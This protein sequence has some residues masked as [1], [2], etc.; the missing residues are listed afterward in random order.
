MLITLNAFITGLIVFEPHFSSNVMKITVNF[1][2]LT[3]DMELCKS[4]HFYLYCCNVILS[5]ALKMAKS[6]QISKEKRA[7]IV[8]LNK[9]GHSQRKIAQI[10]GVSQKGVFSAL[11][12]FAETKSFADRKRSGR[13]RKTTKQNDR[14]I[15]MISK[16]SRS[17]TV[18]DIRAEINQ[19]LA[20]PISETTVTRRLHE[21]G[22]YGR[23]AARKPL[24]RPE[25]I[26]KRLKWAKEHRNWTVDQWKQVMWT[27]ESKFEIFGSKR[28]TYCRRRPGERHKPECIQPT[29][30]FGGGSVMVWGCFSYDG[31]GALVKIDGIMRKEQYHQILQRSAIP[32][33]INLIG[34]GF[35]FQQDNDPK[36]TS[37]LCMNYLRSKESR[38]VLKYMEWPPQSPDANP[39]ELLWDELD[40]EVR[41]LRP[42]SQTHLW[43]CLQTAWRQLRPLALHKL[44]QRMPRICA[45]I[46]E[47]KGR[48]I[49][50]K[51][52]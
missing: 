14:Q 34:N 15:Q 21:V 43:E 49:D 12:R 9:T 28:R 40:R 24:L 11:G 4:P 38:G 8:I 22:L 51:R 3:L 31:V 33:G 6:K 50:E 47:A 16:R 23:V 26:R 45:A 39:I 44:V 29:T 13:P 52:L 2:Y 41:K 37:H 1:A 10:V 35:V 48:Q 46:I 19:V 17:K 25:N 7:Q 27:D 18:P 20:K 42:K 30:K 5:N 32:S 36:H